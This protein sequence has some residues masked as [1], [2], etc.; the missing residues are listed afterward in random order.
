MGAILKKTGLDTIII[1]GRSATPV[2]LEI[3]EDNIEV[4]NAE[5]I[6]G[7]DTHETMKILKSESSSN[8]SISCILC[9]PFVLL[10]RVPN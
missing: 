4:K 9:S 1:T 5:D 6:W 8:I 7:K 10:F 3:T 2:F